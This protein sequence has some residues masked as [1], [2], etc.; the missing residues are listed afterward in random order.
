MKIEQ[1]DVPPFNETVPWVRDS[2]VSPETLFWKTHKKRTHFC[3]VDIVDLLAAMAIELS[4]YF[5]LRRSLLPCY[6]QLKLL[7]D[8]HHHG[9]RG[10]GVILVQVG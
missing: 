7:S 5:N 3:H 8:F 10:S 1:G 9:K 2:P 4:H 6:H